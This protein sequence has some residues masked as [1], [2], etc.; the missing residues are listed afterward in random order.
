MI[1]TIDGPAGAGKSTVARQLAQQLGFRFLDTGAMYR[2]VAR[3]AID[4]QVQLD[5]Q[6]AVTNLVDDLSIELG[7]GWIRVNGVDVTRQIRS[8]EVTAA[9][10]PVA[11]NRAVRTYLSEQQ[12]LVA[13]QGNI[14]TEGR[15]QGTSVFPDANLK[16]F[17]TASPQERARRRQEELE[18]NG[19]PVSLAEVLHQQNQRDKEDASRPIGRLIK[20]DDAIE[21]ISDGLEI[22][23][24]IDRIVAVIPK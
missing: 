5:D 19:N 10:R 20:A 9:I 1:I 16:I 2:A 17:L 6:Q 11:D 22:Q 15:D 14:V 13:A 4:L 8:P 12:R 23:D 7:E 3:A 18:Q 24:V 21:I